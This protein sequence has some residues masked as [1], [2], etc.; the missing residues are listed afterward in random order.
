MTRPALPLLRPARWLVLLAAMAWP[1]WTVA[2]PAL[3]ADAAHQS[4]G[5]VNCA[6]SLCHGAIK[7]WQG[8]RILQNEYSTWLRLDK[9]ANA[10]NLLLT[11]ESRRM[12]EKLGLSRPAHE[13]KVCL[14]CHAHN[15]APEQ[16]GM[17]FSLSDGVSCEACHG[18]AEKWIRSHVDARTTHEENVRNGLY[19]TSRPVD[20]ARLCLSCHYGN[21][22]KLVTHRIM[23]AGHPRL[24]FDLD[25]FSSVQPPHHAIDA[26]WEARKGR[27]DGVRLWAIGQ[28]VAVQS[29]LATLT[30]PVRGRDGF[31][32]ELVVFDCH[33]C[34]HPMSDQRWQPRQGTGPGR[35][36]LNDANL[37][38]LRAIV[39]TVSPQDATAFGTQTQRL[40]K[41]IAG[42]VPGADAL[43]EARKLSRLVE[44]QISRFEKHHFTTADLMRTLQHLTEEGLAGS[45][46][47]Y[48]GAEQAYMALAGVASHLQK[49]GA[50]S[51][52]A[53]QQVS[54]VLSA[55]RNTLGNDEKYAPESFR[56]QLQRLQRLLGAPSPAPTRR[57]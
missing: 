16:R 6:S 44:A 28:A 25:T 43:A 50:L 31:F 55:M 27:F 35:V 21:D 2:Q 19:P 3:P 8:G 52:S 12:A 49:S 29:L 34:H 54:T 17:R 40:H 57:K 5:V 24:T 9:H 32:P 20:V 38:M 13:E 33:A 39:R 23:G 41:A 47:D 7:P 51:L 14:D 56:Q 46:A 10:Y 45:Y 18:P 15:P 37:L 1:L 36:R 53:Q 42:E 22:R 4:L 26:D 48:A 30:D 11:K